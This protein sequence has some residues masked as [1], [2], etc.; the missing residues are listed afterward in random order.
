MIKPLVLDAFTQAYIEAALFTECNCDNPELENLDQDDIPLQQLN[1]IF[2]ECLSFQN[3][4]EKLLK[5]AYRKEGYDERSA[6]HD[7]WFTRNGHGVGY[8]DRGLNKVGEDLTEAA[9]RQGNDDLYKG[10]DG[11]LYFSK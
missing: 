3:D 6:G 8:W 4:H 5:R 1:D 2:Q 11:K 10:D 7:F 9:R